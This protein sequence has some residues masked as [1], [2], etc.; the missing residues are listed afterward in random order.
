VCVGFFPPER[1]QSRLCVAAL[2]AFFDS[3][4]IALKLLYYFTPFFL[5]IYVLEVFYVLFEFFSG[6]EKKLLSFPNFNIRERT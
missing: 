5:N 2:K 3:L 6:E 1:R 4:D